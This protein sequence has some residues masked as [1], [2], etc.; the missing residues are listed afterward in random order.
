[1][2]S[3]D[4]TTRSDVA[5]GAEEEAAVSEA[6]QAPA[7][8]GT[9]PGKRGTPREKTGRIETSAAPAVEGDSPLLQWAG[10]NTNRLLIILLA[11]LAL[12]GVMIGGVWASLYAWRRW[13]RRKSK[14]VAYGERRNGE[15]RRRQFLPVAIETRRGPRRDS[16]RV[17]SEYRVVH[18]DDDKD[19]DVGHL[20][21][22]TEEPTERA[23]QKA[24]AAYPQQHSLKVKLLALYYQRNNKQAFESLLNRLYADL[25]VPG[26]TRPAGS[27]FDALVH[28]SLAEPQENEE[29]MHEDDRIEPSVISGISPSKAEHP[30][31][32][33]DLRDADT[34]IP[35]LGSNAPG[36][37]IPVL[38]FSE[39]S[40]QTSGGKDAQSD[41]DKGLQKEND[42]DLAPGRSDVVR[43]ADTGRKKAGH[44]MKDTN[45]AGLE[46][47]SIDDLIDI[48][49]ADGHALLDDIEFEGV[50]VPDE[51]VLPKR[52]PGSSVGGKEDDRKNLA[53]EEKSPA[54]KDARQRQ[55]RD[56]AIK[57]DLAKAYIDMGDAERA[58]HILD[59]VLKSWNRGDGTDG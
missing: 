45:D 1:V 3:E 37:G 59:E 15:G 48:S 51:P 58:R 6:A 16:D 53:P 52:D 10:D 17:V 57:I 12:L 39:A 55:W 27:A 42:A 21:I 11:L 46:A 44:S 22:H 56:P 35:D 19:D 23:L 50:D 28:H 26:L 43:S 9:N 34:V 20:E 36:D 2:R 18:A 4:E 14:R 31:P 30:R 7:G 24:I 40:S 25:E 13:Y 41:M 5:T 54:T 29:D 47:L 33:E 38:S 32:L 49:S 8:V